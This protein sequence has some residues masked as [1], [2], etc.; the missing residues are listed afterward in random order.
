MK[1]EFN[2]TT[3]IALILLILVA[4][5]LIFKGCGNKP[6][7]SSVEK[8]KSDSIIFVNKK[9]DSIF[10]YSQYRDSLLSDMYNTTDSLYGELDKKDRTLEVTK[11]KVALLVAKSYIIPTK[12]TTARLDNCDSIKKEAIYLAENVADYQKATDQ[13]SDQ[14]VELLYKQ[15]ELIKTKDSLFAA[16]RANTWFIDEINGRLIKENES[17]RKKANRRIVIGPG[18]GATYWDNKITSVGGLFIVYRL[19]RL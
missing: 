8:A 19:G 9:L 5:F 1:I 4:V 15:R 7:R 13:L 11:A 10:R 12:D 18:V 16:L 6:V 2:S 3:L 17:L 14:N